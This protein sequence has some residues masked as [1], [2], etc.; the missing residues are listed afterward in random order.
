M[1]CI[2]PLWAIVTISVTAVAVILSL[3][4]INRKWEKIKFYAFVHFNI[5][6][7]DDGPE[8]LDE[9]D[10]DAYV[11]YRYTAHKYFCIV[12]VMNQPKEHTYNVRYHVPEFIPHNY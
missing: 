5:L 12:S 2:F 7:K 3:I 8:K 1:G 6:T 9:I 11:T 4:V 10:F